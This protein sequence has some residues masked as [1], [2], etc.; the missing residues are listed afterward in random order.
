MVFKCC[1]YDLIYVIVQVVGIVDCDVVEVIV[2]YDIVVMNGFVIELMFI[3]DW[4]SV[5][6]GYECMKQ[7]CQVFVVIFIVVFQEIDN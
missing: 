5:Q 2:E 3:G 7:F 4:V 1:C 6:C